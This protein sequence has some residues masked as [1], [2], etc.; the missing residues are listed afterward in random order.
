MRAYALL[1]RFVSSSITCISGSSV[2]NRILQNN[3]SEYRGEYKI[4]DFLP[5]VEN[6]SGKEIFVAFSVGYNAD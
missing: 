2:Q 5:R 6:Q 3:V 4:D 1:R